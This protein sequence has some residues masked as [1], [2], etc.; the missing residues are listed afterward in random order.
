MDLAHATDNP[1]ADVLVRISE[2]DAKGRSRNVCEAYTRLDPARS[3]G[4]LQLQLDAVAHRFAAGRRIRL[5]VAG[6]SFPRYERNLGT[7][8]D[9]STSTMMMPSR[10]TIVVTDS[11]LLLPV[12]TTDFGRTS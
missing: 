2:V 5:L 3:S 1:H 8:Q 10:H 9:P 4:R 12:P 7:E 11:R 6:G